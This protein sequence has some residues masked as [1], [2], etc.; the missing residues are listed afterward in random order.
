MLETHWEERQNTIWKVLQK[1]ISTGDETVALVEH[2]PSM[3]EALGEGKKKKAS[4]Y[5]ILCDHI[6]NNLL[7]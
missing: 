7:I 5:R 4:K 6:E 3:C 1:N 2:F